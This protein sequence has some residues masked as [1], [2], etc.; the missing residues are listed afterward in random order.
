[1]H[2]RKPIC[3]APLLTRAT[4]EMWTRQKS[5]ANEARSAHLA[6]EHLRRRKRLL[7]ALSATF[8]GYL[9]CVQ[10]SKPQ[11]GQL[12][13]AVIRIWRN[14]RQTAT[15]V[16]VTVKR[17]AGG[18]EHGFCAA[19]KYQCEASHTNAAMRD[20]HAT[21][22][23]LTSSAG[24]EEALASNARESELR[25]THNSLY[26]FER[27]QSSSDSMLTRIMKRGV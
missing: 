15:I 22:S 6:L 18:T 7:E 9:C 11:K 17:I 10:C 8:E 21:A 27:L 3:F 13:M 19:S 14:V 4:G 12:T 24:R 26:E 20:K 16:L 25:Q 1:M 5:S 23:R 2:L